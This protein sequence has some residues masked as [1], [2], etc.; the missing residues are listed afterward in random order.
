MPGVCR[1][2]PSI[3]TTCSQFKTAPFLH[4]LTRR[5]FVPNSQPQ[6]SIETA[7]QCTFPLAKGPVSSVRRATPLFRHRVAPFH[8]ILLYPSSPSMGLPLAQCARPS[9]PAAPRL[10]GAAAINYSTSSTFTPPFII[11]HR[12]PSH[13]PPLNSNPAYTHLHINLPGRARAGPHLKQ[14]KHIVLYHLQ[15]ENTTHETPHDYAPYRPCCLTAT[16]HP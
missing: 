4:A 3:Q 1:L 9:A 7:R 6:P 12:P 13:L 8:R 5:L 10:P 14:Q 2:A 11:L 15:H 16:S